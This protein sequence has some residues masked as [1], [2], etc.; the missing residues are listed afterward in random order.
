METKGVDE[1]LAYRPAEA[2]RVLGCSRD[3]IYKLLAAGELRGWKLRS[4]RLISADELRR[5][6]REREALAATS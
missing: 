4:A 6:I 2:A 5:F 1:R 3:T